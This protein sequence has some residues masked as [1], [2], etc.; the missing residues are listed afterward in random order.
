[1]TKLIFP[2]AIVILALCG[3]TLEPA[4]NTKPAKSAESRSD[5]LNRFISTKQAIQFFK[6][7]ILKGAD[8]VIDNYFETYRTDTC[9]VFNVTPAR[10]REDF[11]GVYA[12]KGIRVSKS[13]DT[14]FVVP[15]ISWCEGNSYCFFDKTLPRLQ[16]DSECCHPSNVFVVDDIDEDGVREI[17]IWYSSCTSRYKS[18][19]I[20][21]LK[22][23][24]WQEIAS[25]DFD[26][27]TQDPTKVVCSSLVKKINKGKF[28][29]CNFLDGDSYWTT[30]TMK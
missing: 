11:E 30:I 3:C 9:E 28:Q 24:A 29:I 27:Q 12:I 5:T 16:T 17:G 1:V 15:R 13:T 14:V 8:A 10:F 26:V 22:K 21:T 25:S 6:D 2:F 19:R 18:L 23:N 20:Y 7:S 4:K